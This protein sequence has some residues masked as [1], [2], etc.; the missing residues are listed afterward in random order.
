[1]KKQ[2]KISKSLLAS[3][4]VDEVAFKFFF[5]LSNFFV[6]LAL[7]SKEFTSIG[8][9]NIWTYWWNMSFIFDFKTKNKSLTWWMTLFL[10]FKDNFI[11]IHLH[12]LN[13]KMGE[14]HPMVNCIGCTVDLGGASK[15]VIKLHVAWS[16]WS[17]HPKSLHFIVPWNPSNLLPYKLTI[18]FQICF[19]TNVY[20]KFRL[21]I[22]RQPLTCSWI[23]VKITT[24][25]EPLKLL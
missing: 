4:I 10:S 25:V 15:H 7:H 24:F 14:M 6:G 1:M 23:I 17:M 8:S 13:F 5:F 20:K 3:I 12:N 11:I 18:M 19:F 21:D 9:W 22:G 16:I 2:L